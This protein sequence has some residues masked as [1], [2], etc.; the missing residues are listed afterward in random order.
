MT[1]PEML[2]IPPLSKWYLRFKMSFLQQTFQVGVAPPQEVWVARP[3]SWNPENG[4]TNSSN[5]L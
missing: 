4:R 5:L 1:H 2:V 3:Q